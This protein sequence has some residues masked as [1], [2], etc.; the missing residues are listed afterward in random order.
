MAMLERN[1]KG[2]IVRRYFIGVEKKYKKFGQQKFVRS[3][4]TNIMLMNARARV[5]NTYLKLANA[6]TTLSKDYKNILISKASE[7]LAGEL[8]LP[9]PKQDKKHIQLEK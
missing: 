2:K 9:L 3:D 4:R 5:A 6:D 7:I 8:L 1:E